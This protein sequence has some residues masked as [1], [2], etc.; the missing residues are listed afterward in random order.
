MY[1][2]DRIAAARRGMLRREAWDLAGLAWRA[3]RR[4]SLVLLAAVVVGAAGL[5][6]FMLLAGLAVG[7]V[8]RAVRSGL[9]SPA[10]HRL[11]G[12]LVAAG[13][14]FVAVQ[15][16]A[17]TRLTIGELVGHKAQGTLRDRAL[18]ACAV[19]G[20][21]SH[22]DRE[23]RAALAVLAGAARGLPLDRATAGLAEITAGTLATLGAI[24][25]LSA[26]QPGVGGGAAVLW[27][28]LR[29]VVSRQN[30]RRMDLLFGQAERLRRADY[31]RRLAVEP[32]AA[33]EIR[34]FG[35]ERWLLGR[36]DAAWS[37]ATG[38]IWSE[39]RAGNRRVLALSAVVIPLY[40]GLFVLVIRDAV[41]GELSLAGFAVCLQALIG[42]SNVFGGAAAYGLD[43]AFAPLAA[44]RVLAS[45]DRG[46]RGHRADHRVG[47]GTRPPAPALRRVLE[48]RDLRFVYPGSSVGDQ[49]GAV[50]RGVSLRIHAGES[51]A[52]VGANG[53]GKTTVLKLLAGFQRPWAGVVLVDGVDLATVDLASWRSQLAMVFQD[54]VRLPLTLSDNVTLL[55]PVNAADG[56][57]GDVLPCLELAGLG[58]LPGRLPRGLDTVLGAGY[59]D[60]VDLSGGQWQRIAL[61]RA[62][63]ALRHGASLLVLDEPTASVD[64]ADELKLVDQ[65][66]AARRG[67]TTIMVSHRFSTVRQ[68]DR[69]VVLDK[70]TIVEQGS[71]DELMR[72]DGHYHR[73][74][75]TQAAPFLSPAAPVGLR[76]DA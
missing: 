72:N 25:L 6:M 43:V 63:F 21:H 8:P 64:V 16:A 34:V 36:L 12:W 50:V 54:F 26:Y 66:L 28:V 75:L 67:L 68:M 37:G 59:D 19:G 31:L 2:A 55:R 47:L 73:M 70:G 57:R 4:R 69:I 3:D 5:P 44:L 74:F 49:H 1:K 56:G 10:G 71:H 42:S 76:Q 29:T 24:A 40:A 15:V 62:F 7:E 33:K 53:A 30:L 17:R 20:G 32:A 22:L 52:L 60:G 27:V 58:E 38:Q 46:G 51:V 23:S 41:A 39:R 61:A 13:L 9:D 18:A 35:L 65:M 45:R 14:V 11:L 48:M